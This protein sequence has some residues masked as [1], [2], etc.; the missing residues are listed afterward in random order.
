[1]LIDQ[2]ICRWSSKSRTFLAVFR[3]QFFGYCLSIR[4][5]DVNC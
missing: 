1:M 3:V 4:F 5:Q 2:R